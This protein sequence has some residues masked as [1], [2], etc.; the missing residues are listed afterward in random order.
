MSTDIFIKTYH[1]DFAWLEWCLK[2][3]KKFASG[4]RN[5]VVVSETGH[6]LPDHIK[7]IIPIKLHYVDFPK[8]TPTYV[9]HGLGYLWQQN[10]KLTWYT[11]T[12]ADEVLVLDSDE[13]LTKPTTPDS[14]KTEGVPNWY[15]TK[16]AFMGDGACWKSSTDHILKTDTEYSG[17]CLTGFILK[18]TTTITLKNYICNLHGVNNIWDIFVKY[19]MPTAS[20]YNIIGCYI[21]SFSSEYNKITNYDAS[22]V[23]NNSIKKEWSWGGL[24]PEKIKQC[25]AVLSLSCE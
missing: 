5:V 8:Q 7:N 20:E 21:W 19:D 16:W 17:M 11:Y 10:I 12:D 6:A 15:F 25:E 14:F 2:S 13:M 1:K 23:F 18:R 24:D 3:I 9:E 4:F 22:K